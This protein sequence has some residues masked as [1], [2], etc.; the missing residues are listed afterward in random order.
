[1]ITI[2]PPATEAHYHNPRS[3]D[4]F[5]ESVNFL[6]KNENICMVLLPRNERQK[7]YLQTEWPGLIEE[8]KLIIPEHLWTV[9]I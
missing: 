4:L 2:R 6:S 9:S 3:Q 1:L 7:E 8:G 5:K